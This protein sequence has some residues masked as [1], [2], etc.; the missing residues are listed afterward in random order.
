MSTNI[1]GYPTEI[2]SYSNNDHQPIGQAS[3]APPPHPAPPAPPQF[4]AARTPEEARQAALQRLVQDLG[5]A[6]PLWPDDADS[7]A[8]SE[9]NG[10]K[11]RKPSSNLNRGRTLQSLLKSIRKTP[12]K[13]TEG[14]P[15]ETTEG[16]ENQPEFIQGL[17]LEYQ[18]PDSAYLADDDRER[19]QS[20]LVQALPLES[21]LHEP[22]VLG[23]SERM[24]AGSVRA[25]PLESQPREPAVLADHERRQ[26]ELVQTY[27]VGLP[28]SE[29]QTAP[30]S[31][32]PSPRRV[33]RRPLRRYLEANP[34]P[35]GSS[36]QRNDEIIP[37]EAPVAE[38]AN[39]Q[40]APPPQDPG[41]VVPNRKGRDRMTQPVG[42]SP[43][44]PNVKSELVH[45]PLRGPLAAA[46]AAQE[47]GNPQTAATS[48]PIGVLSYGALSA[49]RG[50]GA[51]V[52]TFNAFAASN[53]IGRYQTQLDSMLKQDIADFNSTVA[54]GKKEDKD[55][56]EEDKK[57]MIEG[58]APGDGRPSPAYPQQKTLILKRDANN[59]FQYD[60]E[61][62]V[63]LA[64]SKDPDLKKEIAHAKNIHLTHYIA[65]QVGG[66]VFNRSTFNAVRGVIS[67]AGAISAAVA[68]QGGSEAVK[69][70]SY[71]LVGV[72]GINPSANFRNAKQFMRDSK[73]QRVESRQALKIDQYSEQ[74]INGITNPAKTV[75]FKQLKPEAANRAFLDKNFSSQDVKDEA[76]M[77]VTESYPEKKIEIDTLMQDKE[78]ETANN[79]VIAQLREQE[80]HN[81]G[82]NVRFGGFFPA[83]LINDKKNY[84]AKRRLRDQAAGH[85]Y[86]VVRY[87]V[88]ADDSSQLPLFRETLKEAAQ[89]SDRNKAIQ[90]LIQKDESFATAYQLLR[91]MGAGR[92][93]S[94]QMI[95]LQMELT[96]KQNLASDP[97]AATLTDSKNFSRPKEELAGKKPLAGKTHL[98][99]AI[100]V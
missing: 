40:G 97:V 63:K 4:A 67:T 24:Q 47:I 95:R 82:K 84:N 42:L 22:A 66:K 57:R 53:K 15:G 61:A 19:R 65:N 81:V 31:T 90:N 71:A 32:G 6:L 17:A 27:V 26:S 3:Q 96:I 38:P 62:V 73:D 50:L 49:Q 52:N 34:K 78:L 86:D 99:G 59:N 74:N 29:P 89:G 54:R 28:P 44:A 5:S 36:G 69:I 76:L 1:G 91:D 92:D 33:L 77:T 20:D 87:L 46:N 7:G 60:M 68:T 79:A 72:S 88:G 80:R 70:A 45:A 8:Q 83:S 41:F 12:E 48:G 35:T 10:P 25:L 13:K 55:R 2:S 94:M 16:I 30:S 43:Y 23:D 58:R 64:S 39:A 56:I 21:Q 14:T 11:K 93:E 18:P 75:T 85:A 37:A 9:N 100:G 51:L 98:R